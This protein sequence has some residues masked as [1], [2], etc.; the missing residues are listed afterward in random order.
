MLISDKV[1]RCLA[2]DD[3]AN[4]LNKISGHAKKSKEPKKIEIF[5]IGCRNQN[6]LIGRVWPTFGKINMSGTISCPMLRL[7]IGQETFD[8]GITGSY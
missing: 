4:R 7:E 2:A 6:E 8:A 3:S 5:T 1:S